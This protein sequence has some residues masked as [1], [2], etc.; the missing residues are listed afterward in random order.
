[1][2]ANGEGIVQDDKQAAC[3]FRKAADQ[4]E[5]VAQFNLGWM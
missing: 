4:G 2:Y 1:M 5:A 3:W